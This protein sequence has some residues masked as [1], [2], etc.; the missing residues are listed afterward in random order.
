[1]HNE[2]QLLYANI[3]A[4]VRIAITK[5]KQLSLKG[6]RC[7]NRNVRLWSIEVSEKGST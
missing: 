7:L 1:M 6:A 4:A 2:S 5:D 3:P